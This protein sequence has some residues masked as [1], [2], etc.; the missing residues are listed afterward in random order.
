MDTAIVTVIG[1]VLLAAFVWLSRQ[2]ARACAHFIAAW[3]VV[4][5]AHMGYGVLATGH[6]LMDELGA[7][8]AIAGFPVLLALALRK[9]FGA[10]S[11]PSDR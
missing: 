2:R 9:R 6:A 3:V 7:H 8:V 1:L 4:C 11:A 10:R 5:A